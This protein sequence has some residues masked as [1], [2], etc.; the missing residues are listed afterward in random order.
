MHVLVLGATGYVGGR[1]VPELLTAGHTVRCAVRSPAKLDARVWRDR[2]DVVRGDVTDRASMDAAC[3]DIDAVLFLVHAMDG[4]P[5]FAAREA[6]GATTVRDAA[7][8]AGVQRILYLGGLGDE[9]DQLSK[10]LRSR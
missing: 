6:A 7:A 9:K 4:Q 5:D 8:G 3:A 2:V 1:V 10:H